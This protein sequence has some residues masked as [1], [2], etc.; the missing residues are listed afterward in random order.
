MLICTVDDMQQLVGGG[1][2]GKNTTIGRKRALGGED[3]GRRGQ[4]E[5]GAGI[6]WRER[7]DEEA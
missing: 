6:G 1:A 2:G 5:G 7:E 4:W 3:M